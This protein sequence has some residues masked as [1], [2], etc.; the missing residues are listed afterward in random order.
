MPGNLFRRSTEQKQ[1][2]RN[3]MHLARVNKK[4]NVEINSTATTGGQENLTYFVY[5]PWPPVE[6]ALPI[7]N[8]SPF[9]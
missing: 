9:C 6:A 8:V 2:V 4:E 5:F 3:K 1:R 7:S